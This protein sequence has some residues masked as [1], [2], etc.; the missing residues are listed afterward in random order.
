[1]GPALSLG[2]SRF[3]AELKFGCGPRYYCNNNQEMAWSPI[4]IQYKYKHCF[5]SRLFLLIKTLLLVHLISREIC[6]ESFYERDHSHYC[7]RYCGFAN[8]SDVLHIS[9]L[10][11]LL[12]LFT[13]N[14]TVWLHYI[15]SSLYLGSFCSFSSPAYME[16]PT[17]CCTYS[18]KMP[19]IS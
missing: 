12:S 15:L 5:V 18:K 16:M 1:M 19:I 17:H 6:H 2:G 7:E 4:Y 14:I 9:P 8:L 10:F 13:K 3:S 11:G